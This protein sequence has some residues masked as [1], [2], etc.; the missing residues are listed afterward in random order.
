MRI[1]LEGRIIKLPVTIKEIAKLADVSASTVSMVLND[2]QGISQ[3]TRNRVLK[4]AKDH[5]YNTSKKNSSVEG[6]IQ[7]TIN[8][9]NSKIIDDTPFFQDLIEGIEREA[10]HSSFKLVITYTNVNSDAK[11]I[12]DDAKRRSV[13]GLILLGTEMEESDLIPYLNFGIPILL[14]DSNFIGVNVNCVVIDNTDGTFK[15]TNYLIENG[16]TE[17]GYLKSSIS[18]QNFTERFEGYKKAL[19]R[20]S[21]K[22]NPEYVVPIMPNMKEAYNDMKKYLQMQPSLATAYLADNDLIAIG[23]IKAL[24]EFSI[25]TPEQVSVIGFDDMPFCTMIEPSLTTIKVNKKIFGHIAVD[26][27]IDII[28]GRNKEIMKTMLGVDIIYR[29]SVKTLL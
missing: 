2:R 29:N 19:K 1:V 18:I 11:S 9:K 23:A 21:I 17:I 28:K 10:R 15:G 7:L 27:L 12:I 20:K 16:H 5:G 13:D 24:K 6:T 8:K 14:L 25:S 26:N 4:I 3:S 22:Y